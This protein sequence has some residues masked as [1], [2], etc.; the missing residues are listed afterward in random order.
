MPDIDLTNPIFSDED[1]ARAAPRSPALARW[2]NVPVLRQRG[3]R[4]PAQGR[5]DGA[6]LVSLQRIAAT[7]S[8]S[9][10][11]ASWSARTSR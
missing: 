1:K 8:R 6:G 4:E 2:R 11:A 3:R 7:S 5:L 10:S 9:A